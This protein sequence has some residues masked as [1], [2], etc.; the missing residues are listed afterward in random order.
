MTRPPKLNPDISQQSPDSLPP[1]LT[2]DRESDPS[3]IVILIVAACLLLLLLMFFAV[4]VMGSSSASNSGAEG[5]SAGSQVAK[6][7]TEH[8]ARE[9]PNQE[10]EPESPKTDEEHGSSS[11]RT[12]E[13]S[14]K[15]DNSEKE[16]ADL[17]AT[18][19]APEKNRTAR[20]F[21][22]GSFF[23][24]RA[25]GNRFVYVVDCSGSMAGGGLVNAK[26]EL[27][28]SIKEL[29]SK[30]SFSVYFFATDSFPMFFP[31]SN[32]TPLAATP[33]NKLKVFRWIDN[34]DESGGTEPESSLLA[35]LQLEPDAIYLLTDGAFLNSTIDT[36]SRA[37]VDSKAIHAIGFNSRG[38]ETLLKDLARK[39]RGVYRFV[40]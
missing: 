16:V 10:I 40:K 6:Q 12:A 38:G 39:N 32:P 19:G 21:A 3:L 28:R 17:P 18:S 29:G 37:N 20:V 34:F 25:N 15:L 2:E 14:N 23:G 33:D 30:Q 26:K 36:V 27:K 4:G 7:D 35:A 13:E 22:G 31:Q 11:K 5:A 24:I 8:D 9:T 1:R